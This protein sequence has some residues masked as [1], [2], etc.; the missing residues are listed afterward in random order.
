[1]EASWFFSRAVFLALLAECYFLVVC[2]VAM[3][4]YLWPGRKLLSDS[5]A[6]F[7]IKSLA[8]GFLGGGMLGYSLRRLRKCARLM[9]RTEAR[10]E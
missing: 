7:V 1:M 4:E 9:C 6:L 8:G 10:C 2:V 5:A 3:V